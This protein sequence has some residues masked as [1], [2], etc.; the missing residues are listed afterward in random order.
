M[1]TTDGVQV[2][3]EVVSGTL[4]CSGKLDLP[5]SPNA[6]V[7]RVLLGDSD[8]LQLYH[9]GN[10]SYIDDAGV[11]SLI[12]RT[13]TS[14]NVTIKSTN[15]VMAK[16]KTADS[17]ELYHNNSKKF[18]TT[19][20]GA[21][22]TGNLAFPSGNGIDF[23]STGQGG[24]SSTMQNELLDDYE[25]GVWVPTAGNFTASGT[26]HANYTKIGRLVHLSLIHI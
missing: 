24:C 25:E 18:E 10:D 2:T 5:D 19:S 20:S 4:H 23:S 14:S 11:G 17:V 22:I 6:T 12:L 9:D 7:G 3:G 8:D 15:D 16:F 21:T 26:Y 13:T 1:T